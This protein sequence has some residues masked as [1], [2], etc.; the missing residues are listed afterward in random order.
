VAQE[1]NTSIVTARLNKRLESKLSNKK[2][3]AQ[4]PG[5]FFSLHNWPPNLNKI[6]RSFPELFLFIDTI[7]VVARKLIRS[8]S[9]YHL[10][11]FGFALTGGAVSFYLFKELP[12]NVRLL[13]S[14]TVP[15]ADTRW[16]FRRSAEIAD[17]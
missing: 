6:Q 2:P 13:R 3:G 12:S 14:G 4:S 16:S 17:T 15:N 11:Q 9:N 5:F 1:R 10:F 8:E 7:S